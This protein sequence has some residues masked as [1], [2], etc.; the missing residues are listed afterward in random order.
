M[1]WVAAMNKRTR[2]GIALIIISWLI[3]LLSLWTVLFLRESAVAGAAAGHGASR[4]KAQ[5]ACQSAVA[6]VQVYL[7]NEDNQSSPGQRQPWADNPA[8]LKKIAVTEKH[9]A[10]VLSYDL[11]SKALRYGLSDEASRINLLTATAEQLAALPGM[12]TEIAEAIIDWRDENTDASENGAEDEFYAL[13]ASPYGT[14][15]QH[16]ETLGELLFVR[17]LDPLILYGE[18][19]NLNGRLDANEDD[20]TEHSPHD[21]RDGQLDAGLWRYL[22]I[23][24]YEKD[25]DPEG[26][27]RININSA[28]A[29]ELTA[30]L[31]EKLSPQQI[32]R[33]PFTRPYAS[34][35]DLT[36]V[37]NI[38]E[39]DLLGVVDQITIND[40]E[41]LIGRVNV[42]TAPREV[43]TA[44]GLDEEEVDTLIAFRS[45]KTEGLNTLAWLIT[46]LGLE[47]FRKLAN[48]ATVR[49]F[50]YRFQAQGWVEGGSAFARR[51]YVV[52]RTDDKFRIL[53]RRDFQRY[54]PLR[55][56]EK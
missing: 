27:A 18:D 32:Q 15:N 20:G 40:G 13:L 44:L 1:K 35:A 51:W 12:T 17:Q 16:F 52:D 39:E 37:S 4:Y 34:I 7:S 28:S 36:R 54:G 30:A 14:K 45:D 19:W 25:V 23:Y 46:E 26:K 29:E 22:T 11:E 55:L 47:T 33:I 24:S 49:S 56:P 2:R 10:A 3:I 48:L 9:F 31:G 42:V 50:Q 8:E 38:G 43:L 21:N 5:L 6:M 41:F 53:H